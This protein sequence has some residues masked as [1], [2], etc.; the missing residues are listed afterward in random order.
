MRTFLS[1]A[2]YAARPWAVALLSLILFSCHS[3]TM[4]PPP[5]PT[6]LKFTVQPANT[7]AVSNLAAVSVSA[8]DASGNVLT[9]Y[10]GQVTVSL[11]TMFSPVK[12]A[13]S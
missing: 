11:A 10:T 4:S 7:D 5:N 13:M 12:S 6:S 8:L 1:A 2:H 9:S 3:D